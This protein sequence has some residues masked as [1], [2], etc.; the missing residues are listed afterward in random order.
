[1][2]DYESEYR[3]HAN[4]FGVDPEPLLVLRAHL[5]PGGG[6]VLDIGVGQGRNAL[7]LARQGLRV[8][9][10]D[11]SESAV[12]M[13]RQ[14]ARDA[15]LDLDLWCGDVHDYAPRE[16]FDA[17]LVLGLLMTLEPS[18]TRRLLVRIASWSRPDAL[19]FVTA[20]HTG[21]PRFAAMAESATS[22]VP[23]CFRLPGGELR[24]F[25]RPDEILDL[26]SG[27]EV[28]HHWEGLGPWHQHGTG[29]RERHGEVHLVARRAPKAP[30]V[31]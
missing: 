9:G 3:A 15:G 5:I 22:V 18:E 8:T 19:L 13:T 24:T 6:R 29:P 12:E 14:R 31:P 21:D 2:P 1:M 16:P 30:P 23:G 26:V 28:A 27:W 25:L 17:V 20:W 10:L 7:P 4:F 11:L